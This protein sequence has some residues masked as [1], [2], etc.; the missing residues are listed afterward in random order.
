MYIGIPNQVNE[1]YVNLVGDIMYPKSTFNYAE[2]NPA[3]GKVTATVAAT[4]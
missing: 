4:G 2:A 3:E 1:D